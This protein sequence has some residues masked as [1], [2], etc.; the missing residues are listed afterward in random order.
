MASF[1]SDTI[2]KILVHVSAQVAG[3]TVRNAVK[4]GFVTEDRITGM[5]WCQGFNAEAEA[6]PSEFG[7][8]QTT[9]AITFELLRDPDEGDTLWTNID[10]I[11]TALFGDYTLTDTVKRVW[12]SEYLV[13]EASS[14]ERTIGVFVVSLLVYA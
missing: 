10:D 13:D 11:K 5:P 4:D 6:V 2:D 1:V 14:R 8:E 7:Q 12:L 3:V 9:Y